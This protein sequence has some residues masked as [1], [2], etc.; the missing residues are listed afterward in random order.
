[1]ITLSAPLYTPSRRLALLERRV[2]HWSARHGATVLRVG[3]GVVFAWFGLLKLVPGLS[4]AEQLL[5][6]T[7]SPLVDPSWFVPLLAAWEC[8]LGL[9]LMTGRLPRLTLLLL[10]FHLGGTCLPVLTCPDEVWTRFPHA[11]TLEGQYMVKNLVLVGAGL[12]LV[13][14]LDGRRRRVFARAPQDVAAGDPS[15]VIPPAD[16]RK[17]AA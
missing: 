15:E 2:T 12:T 6:K 16:F 4:P 8:G 13:G 1:M 14:R 10:F 17:R 11:L 7:V 3:L 5:T 9:G